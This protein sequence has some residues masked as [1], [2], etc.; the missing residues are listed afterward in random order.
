MKKLFIMILACSLLCTTIH[1]IHATSSTIT[2]FS[3]E[4]S[5]DGYYNVGEGALVEASADDYDIFIDMDS[6]P[7]VTTLY[8]QDI[9]LDDMLSIDYDYNTNSRVDIVL[10]GDNYINS[11]M[12]SFRT[13]IL[14]EGSLETEWIN[15]A[16]SN[17][18]Y[19]LI[20]ENVDVVIKDLNFGASGGVD[21]LLDVKGTATLHGGYFGLIKVQSTGTLNL[22]GGVTLNGYSQGE[23]F[24][25]ILL[26]EPGGELHA[27][28]EYYAI[29]SEFYSKKENFDEKIA[30]NMPENYLPEDIILYSDENVNDCTYI[31]F[32][33]K[34]D[35]KDVYTIEE[36][37][38]GKF[39]LYQRYEIKTNQCE[40]SSTLA[41]SGDVITLTAD[42]AEPGYHFVGYKE[43]NDLG[44]F[45][46]NEFVMPD[47]NVEITA[48]YEA[49]VISNLEL[50]PT[51]LNFTQLNDTAQLEATYE[52]NDAIDTS[53][54]WSSSNEA[55]ATVS[56]NGLV[57]AIG[58]GNAV[59]TVTNEASGLS[60]TCQV[61]VTLEVAK[62]QI[63][64]QDCSANYEEASEGTF[65]QL[66]PSKAEKGYRFSHYEGSGGDFTIADH[67]FIM[68]AF[69]VKVKAIFKP[70]LM[71]DLKFNVEDLEFDEID[72]T[73]V[74]IP[75][76]RPKV[77]LDDSFIWESEDE[78]V[79]IV[80]EKGNVTSKGEG[81]TTITITNPAS[82]LSTK[83][84]IVVKVQE[85][86]E[87]L[88]NEGE[89]GEKEEQ[90]PPSQ[91]EE[92]E[93]Q[94]S[95]SEEDE[96]IKQPDKDTPPT[97]DDS[98]LHLYIMMAMIS[99]M[100]VAYLW[101][102]QSEIES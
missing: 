100:M 98:Q 10:K 79:A 89:E 35:L 88:P 34:D 18:D 101:K 52:A 36:D 33:K 21:S 51:E 42:E 45:S 75:G 13:H 20:G 97:S 70:I 46:G 99:M 102:K 31:S 41:G 60:S 91:E 66:V 58:E 68:P 96:A 77:V 50:N 22:F 59:I 67:A 85:E 43:T 90:T 4:H 11:I 56:Q 17:D 16:G 47:S 2:I 61:N 49:N 82:G 44:R 72:D 3:E 40:A 93:E 65:V 1:P 95:P 94:T 64:T 80:D 9:H 37:A 62:Y 83:C 28:C 15:G 69:D 71:E 8:L 7:D 86:K 32:M 30:Y 57:T 19:L 73:K 14:G 24:D 81:T 5:E 55:V 6:E 53:L 23:K 39:S 12:G 84:K 26:I 29:K 63:E 74:L 92:K 38:A 48:L 78:S 87:E 27:D 25:D 54:T 76:Y